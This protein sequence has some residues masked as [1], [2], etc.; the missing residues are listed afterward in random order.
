LV[1]DEA[2]RM[3]DMGFEP[4]IRQ[5]VEKNGMPGKADRITS[6][7][8][9]TFAKD[10]QTI[11]RDFL[12]PSYVFLSVGRVGSASEN[13]TQRLLQA[14][15]RRHKN[16]LL[17]ETLQDVQDDKV[18]IFANTKKVVDSVARDLRNEGFQSVSI[19]G[20]HTQAMRE[21]SLRKFKQGHSNILVGTDVASRGLDIPNVKMVINFDLPIDGIDAYVHRIGRTG[22]AGHTGEAV[23]FFNNDF[24]THMAQ[25][26]VKLLEETGQEPTDF[27][28][29]A[30]KFSGRGKSNSRG[31]GGRGGGMGR[32]MDN[33]GFNNNS[34]GGGSYN[35]R[36]YNEPNQHQQG[37]N[38]YQ[39]RGDDEGYQQ[40]AGRG[41]NRGGRGGG[42][43]N[44][45]MDRGNDDADIDFFEEGNDRYV[46]RSGDR[47]GAPPSTR[48]KWNAGQ[49]NYWDDDDDFDD[50]A[51]FD[52][53]FPA[54]STRPKGRPSTRPAGSAQD[55][56]S[57]SEFDVDEENYKK[58]IKNRIK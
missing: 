22:R 40:P 28:G 52:D 33:R 4:Q 57:F 46:S 32:N 16:D 13:I 23:S 7:F 31:G 51:M 21:A 54:Q 37:G 56:D 25:D 9:A 19:H 41:F 12:R 15:D 44:N 8:S 50:D 55:Q 5:L 26:L 30:A 2:D 27:L 42:F 24:D 45:R 48:P 36:S 35:N 20:D 3:L 10:I 6:M 14:H 43:R 49:G 18:L 38:R 39:Q 58:F 34:R 53:E 17:L 47:R 29:Y 1:L 11:A